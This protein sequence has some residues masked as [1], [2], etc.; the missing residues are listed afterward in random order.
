MNLVAA[1]VVF[2]LASAAWFVLAFGVA[3]HLDAK[4][5]ATWS[6]WHILVPIAL[7]FVGG[8]IAARLL[9]RLEGNTAGRVGVAVSSVTLP[10]AVIAVV[11]LAERI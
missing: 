4:G 10:L 11:G 9:F 8:A 5:V 2:W 6:V 7:G 3:A 1:T